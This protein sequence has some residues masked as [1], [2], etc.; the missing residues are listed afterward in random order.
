MGSPHAAGLGHAFKGFAL[1]C[2]CV[3]PFLRHAGKKHAEGSAAAAAAKAEAAATAAEEVNK[4]DENLK[5]AI[6]LSLCERP[7]TV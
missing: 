3:G 5:C 1:N 2:K 4:L 6:C 7:V